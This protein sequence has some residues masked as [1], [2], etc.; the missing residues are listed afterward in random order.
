[1]EIPGHNVVSM[2][3]SIKGM[4]E[5]HLLLAEEGKFEDPVRRLEHA[6]TALKTAFTKAEEALHVTRRI[7][8]LNACVSEGDRPVFSAA[9]CASVNDAWKRARTNL[10]WKFTFGALE[11]VTR[12]PK[13]F[14][15][16]V[17]RQRDLSEILYNLA[18]NALQAIEKSGKIIFRAEYGYSSDQVPCAILTLADTGPGIPESMIERIFSPFVTTK[19]PEEG[20]GLGLSIVRDLVTQNSGKISVASSPGSGTA[21]TLEFQLQSQPSEQ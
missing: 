20:N 14:P 18:N 2:L 12:I 1:M 7:R 13:D 21:F 15:E 11:I 16:V 17:C 8:I 4:A 19:T 3:Y 6:E 5:S 9:I 10:P